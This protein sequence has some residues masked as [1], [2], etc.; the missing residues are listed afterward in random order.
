MAEND[1]AFSLDELLVV[2]H[3]AHQDGI[4]WSEQPSEALALECDYLHP[5]LGDDICSARLILQQSALAEVIALLV[6]MYWYSWLAWLQC[7]CRLSLAAHNHVEGVTLGALSDHVIT[8]FEPL[9]LNGISQFGSLVGF[10]VLENVDL[11]QELLVLFS[12]HL[13]AVFDDMV[14]GASVEGP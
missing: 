14:E 6:V 3:V 2:L 11:G 12:L 9:L 4:D 5:R 1:I 13:C 8:L 7:L 10:H